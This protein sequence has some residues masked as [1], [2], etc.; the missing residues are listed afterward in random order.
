MKKKNKC[1]LFKIIKVTQLVTSELQLSRYL[2][3]TFLS[4]NRQTSGIDIRTVFLMK[5]DFV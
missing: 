3:R 2:I 1:L 4:I 5:Y